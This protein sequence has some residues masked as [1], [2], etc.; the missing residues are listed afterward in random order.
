MNNRKVKEEIGYVEALRILTPREI[1]ILELV[2]NGYTCK[3]V[4]EILRLS[5][6]TVRTHV[7]NIKRKLKVDGYRGLVPWYREN[8]EE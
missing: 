7:K 4:A 8:W 5:I 3:E 6:H 1:E 2:G